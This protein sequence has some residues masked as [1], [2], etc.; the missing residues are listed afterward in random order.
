MLS[1]TL[2]YAMDL[3]VL[4]ARTQRASKKTLMR[5]GAFVGRKALDLVKRAKRPRRRKRKA[6]VPPPTAKAKQQLTPVQ[7]EKVKE[8]YRNKRLREKARPRPV[9]RPGDPPISHGPHFRL[10]RMRFGYDA[11][12]KSVVA[13]PV[14]WPGSQTTKALRSLEEGGTAPK[15]DLEG[16]RVIGTVRVRPR[17][18]M[19]KALEIERR[20]PRFMAVWKDEI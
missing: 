14:I 10:R 3:R 7:R 8:W 18:Y 2:T 15:L 11:R 6:D 20:N 9:S 17:P 19:S 1:I 12:T 5:Q 4:D 16:K 13:G